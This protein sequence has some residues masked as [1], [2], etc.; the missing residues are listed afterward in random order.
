M[1]SIFDT[2]INI[3]NKENELRTNKDPD[4]TNVSKIISIDDLKYIDHN[5][6]NKIVLTGTKSKNLIDKENF[7][8]EF[9]KK[10][11]DLLTY[12]NWDN[13]IVAGGSIVNILTKCNEKLNDIDLFVYGLDKEKAKNKID[14]VINCIKQKANDM[15]YETRVYINKN[16]VNIYVFDTKKLLQIQIIMRLYDT[17]AHVLVG[18]D[19][20][21]CCICYTGKEILTTERGLYALKYRVN[22]ANLK[23]RSPSYENRLIKYSFRGFDVITDF[24]YEKIYNKLFFMAPENYGFTR[25]LEQELINNGQLKNIIFSNTLRFRKTASYTSNQSFYGKN[26]LEIKNIKDTENCI[27]KYN[28]NIDDDTLKFKEY[29]IKNIDFM[30]TNVMDQITGSFNP[31]T[32]E[33]WINGQNETSEKK[34]NN[35]SVSSKRKQSESDDESKE[36]EESEE[37]EEPEEPEESEESN[38]SNESNESEGKE[39]SE[40]SEESEEKE[41]KIC[42]NFDDPLKRSQKFINLKYNMY[43]NISEYENENIHDISNFDAKCLAV[44]YVENESDVIKII[45][46]KY[47]PKKNNMYRISPV[48]I[49][50]L[51]G[52]TKLA[53]SLMKNHGYETVKELIYMMDNDKL[54]TNYCNAVGKSCTD[55]DKTLVTKFGCENISDD[56]H[57]QNKVNNNAEEFYQLD[58][59]NML[60]NISQEKHL[61]YKKLNPDNLPF[62][63]I[64]LLYEKSSNACFEQILTKYIIQSFKQEDIEN[65]KRVMDND[66][67]LSILNFVVGTFYK[68]QNEKSL[69]THRDVVKLLTMR[70]EWDNNLLFASVHDKLKEINYIHPYLYTCMLNVRNPLMTRETIIKLLSNNSKAFDIL[71]SYV[72]YLDD[73]ELLE[74]MILGDDMY[75]KLK[76]VYKVEKINNSPNITKYFTKI[77][78]DRQNEKVK[79]NKIL[80]NTEDHISA[81]TDGELSENY[82]RCEN[83]FGMTP[84]DNIIAKLLL[85]FN[86]VF[87]KKEYMSDKD[88]TTLKNMRKSINNIR[89]D[90]KYV[91]VEKEYFYSLELH[92]LFFSKKDLVGQSNRDELVNQDQEESC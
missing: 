58:I 5:F 30:E 41:E 85:M 34:V 2:I 52:R 37:S 47:V 57:N 74:K 71:V 88:L 83:V 10:T 91:F 39:E 45:E 65:I 64:K 77:E 76:Y 23:R 89:R 51:L 29:N 7:N 21:C 19:V 59:V 1:T 43:K 6:G 15:K 61:V 4:M 27:T 12:I 90:N 22:V 9:S 8:M 72:L 68:V 35:K 79:S 25:L 81:I 78:S 16:V 49:A 80:K 11:F 32:D 82:T 63:A 86:K 20:D 55:V 84:D 62:D 14:H 36:S 44:M 42:N 56:I 67:E 69:K 24:E 87:N 33:K 46:N 48:Q 53:I 13:I 73:I 28:A 60:V 31:I 66:K 26:E 75:V 17:L 70:N 3:S 38:E 18:F 92:N 40:E 54:F 50:I